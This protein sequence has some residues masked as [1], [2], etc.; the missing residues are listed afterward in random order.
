[1]PSSKYFFLPLPVQVMTAGMDALQTAGMDKSAPL[2]FIAHSMG[3]VI[4]QEYCITAANCHA[5]I[6]MGSG[7]NRKYHNVT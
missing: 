3:G 2:I 4:T 7:L 5:Q 6:L 1:M